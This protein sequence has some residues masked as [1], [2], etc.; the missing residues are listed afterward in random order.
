MA[1]RVVAALVVAA[2]G[3][4]AAGAG[5]EWDLPP[6]FPAPRVPPDNPMTVAKVDLGRALFFDPRLSGDGTLA[7]AGCHRPELAF[8]DGRARAEGVHGDRHRYATMSLANVAYNLTLGW[9]DPSLDRLERQAHV[10]LSNDDPV[11]MGTTAREARVLARFRRDPVATE[12]F[13][14]AFPDAD[15]PLTLDHVVR[16]IASYE[17]TLVS[18]D[19]PYDRFVAGDRG[20]LTADARAGM[21]LF[22]SSRL[23]CSECHAGFNF[24]GAV[25]HSGDEAL[26][27]GPDVPRFHNT[28]LYDTDGAGAYPAGATGVHRVTGQAADMGKF[29][30]PTLRNVAVTAPY[31]HDG[32]VDTLD[33]VVRFYAA[34]GRG[35][36]ARSRL[37]D[38]PVA[39]FAL[40]DAERASVV[41]FLEA[42]TDRGFLARAADDARRAVRRDPP[43]A[44]P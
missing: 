3:G 41:A 31:M 5:W 11:E 26:T 35:A 13:R 25:T 23:R 15:D 27:G 7:C 16:A 18:G 39:G 28:G 9:D 20:A 12:R 44:R 37:K 10:P 6:G 22:F 33:A 38:P 19:A 24:S 8:T 17:R 36:G 1:H 42:L 43:S 30:A 2:A 34:G 29:R 14:L 32:S 40:T 21:R 4:L